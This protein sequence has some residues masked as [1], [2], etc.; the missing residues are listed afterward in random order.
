MKKAWKWILGILIGLVLIG[1]IV[2]AGYWVA[3]NWST[4]PWMM[5]NRLAQRGEVERGAPWQGLPGP[6][7]PRKH[8]PGQNIPQQG[9]PPYFDQNEMPKYFNRGMGFHPFGGLMLVGRLV[10]GL[11]KLVLLGLVIFLAVTLALRQKAVKQP[12]TASGAVQP[13]MESTPVATLACPHCA[14]QIQVDWKHCPYCGNSR[15]PAQ[16]DVPLA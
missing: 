4:V 10:G 1:V 16:P 3:R 14:R 9:L 11:F 8:L 15:E 5:G 2:G 7:M 6:G 12:A 13:A